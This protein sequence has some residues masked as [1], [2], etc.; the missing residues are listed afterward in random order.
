MHRICCYSISGERLPS[1]RLDFVAVQIHKK[2]TFPVSNL[3]K[4]DFELEGINIMSSFGRI[5]QCMADSGV[6]ALLE[7]FKCFSEDTP[8]VVDN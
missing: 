5:R 2:H 7:I 6:L 8:K 4:T 1:W 3:I